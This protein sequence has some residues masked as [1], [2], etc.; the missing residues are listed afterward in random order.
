M[1]RSHETGMT[2]CHTSALGGGTLSSSGQLAKKFDISTCIKRL[3]LPVSQYTLM[4]KMI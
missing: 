4:H 2:L 3:H 1:K